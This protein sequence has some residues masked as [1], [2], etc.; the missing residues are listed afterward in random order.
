MQL[1]LLA[2]CGDYNK[3]KT[4]LA[5]GADA[6]YVGGDRFGLRAQ[7]K[8]FDDK[9]LAEAV[10]YTHERGKKLYVTCNIVAH[11]EDFD[12]MRQYFE[13]LESISVDAVIISDIGV[14]GLAAETLK[15]TH[16]HV[17]TQAN[18][19]NKYA[20]KSYVAMGA[21]RIVLAR[22]LTLAEIREIKDYVGDT[23]EL[24][25]FIH[26]AMCISHSGR[27]LLSNY[28]T[29]R[30]GNRGACVQAC[31]WEYTLHEKSRADNQ[32]TIQ[33]DGRGTYIL[34][35]KDL[36]MLAHLDDV[37]AAGVTSFKIEGRMKSQYY[38]ATVV[39]AYR[40]AMDRLIKSDFFTGDIQG[41]LVKTS[42]RDYTTGFYY[43]E[44]DSV[45]L[46]T[47]QASCDYDFIAEVYGYDS[48]RRA[49]IIEQRN[50]FRVGD[51]LEILSSN[52]KYLNKT[53][54]ANRIE[55]MDGNAVDDAR[56]VQQ[57]LY[58]YTD[59]ELN[60]RDILRKRNE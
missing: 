58:L 60:E 16:I 51:C 30:D 22:E 6:V 23:V 42:H 35:S 55:D 19:T 21:K 44:K 37:A 56:L 18:V 52:T 20:C 48:V 33:E 7:A 2:P 17:S 43:G 12:G 59:F 54:V 14:M 1:E 31:R 50:R 46:L 57:K 39:N 5:F 29:G 34:N 10:A 53:L 3:L 45:N 4:A 36:N 15:N 8:N 32:L 25:A 26:G 13:Y 49:L 40:I 11:N 24:E 38:V 27:C 9:Q 28:L 41:E 47:S